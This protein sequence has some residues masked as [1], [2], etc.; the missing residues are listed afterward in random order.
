M[1]DSPCCVIET[2]SIVQREE[3]RKIFRVVNV[4]GKQIKVCRVDGCL[5]SDRDTIKCDYLFILDVSGSSNFALVEFKGTDHVH[6]VRQL[7][8]T[9]EKLNLRAYGV[10]IKSYIVGAPA[11]K[12]ATSF[13]NELMKQR[14]RFAAAKVSLPIRENTVIEVR[15]T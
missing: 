10:P 14:K 2:S 9:A 11:P 12:A 15:V 3:N 13:Q 5:I 7:I 8:S 1:I 6:A 4:N